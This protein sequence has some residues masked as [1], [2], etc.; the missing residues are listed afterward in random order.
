MLGIFLGIA[1]VVSLISLGSGLR[2]AITGQFASL[3]TDV[4]EIT[5]VETGFGPPGATA[6][7]K[8][9][10]HDLQIIEDSPGVELAIPRLIRIVRAEFNRITSFVYIGSIPDSQDSIDEIVKSSGIETIEGRFLRAEDRGKIVLGNDFTKEDVFDKQV[11]VGNSIT[12]NGQDFEVIGILKRTSTFT[13][14]S[15]ILM[16]QSDLKDILDI[17][18]EIDLITVKVNDENNIET[19]AEEIERRMRKDRN[20]DEGEEDF[21]VQTP[22]QALSSVNTI[23]NIVNIVVS[24][25]ALIAL[26]IGGI[27]IANTMFTSV[28][29]RT[30]EIG[31]MKAIG[32]RNRDILSVFIIEAGILGLV[33]GIVGASIGLLL[34]F[35]ASQAANVALGE[36]IFTIQPSYPLLFGSIAFSFFIGIFSGIIPAYQ[37]SK[38]NTVDAL[39]K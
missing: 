8:L 11:R 13:L 17:D 23:L 24:G 10:E 14:N 15:V 1:A 29:E 31:V 3:S 33:G 2:T 4:L 30:K 27:G 36:T 26:L 20:Q 18:D 39:R 22:T 9:T 34:A 19:I 25:I 35:G 32:A 28:L 7:R 37:A 21:S 5:S 38:L 16:P 6:V 12:V